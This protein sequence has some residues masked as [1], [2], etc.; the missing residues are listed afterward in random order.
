VLK[1]L[2]AA[3]KKHNTSNVTVALAW[4]MHRKS[5]TAP[6]VS[7]TSLDQLKT[8]IAAPELKLDAESVAALDKASA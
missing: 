7:A 8:L 2:D 3:G 1:A 5:I 6:I 4:L